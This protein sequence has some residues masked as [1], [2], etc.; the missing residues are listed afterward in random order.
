VGVTVS[1]EN[2]NLPVL[3]TGPFAE[4]TGRRFTDDRVSIA[5]GGGRSLL[6]A[7]AGGWDI[8]DIA[9]NPIA[10]SIGGIY[11][12]DTDYNLTTG[13]FEDY[14]K[15]LGGGGTVSATV[16]LKQPPRNLPRLVATGMAA[17]RRISENPERCIV[18]IRSW[19]S[20]T[21]LLRTEPFSRRDIDRVRG[22]CERMRFDL[23]YYYGMEEDEANRFNI[24][25]DS[26]YHRTILPMI[27]GDRRFT[28][29]YVFSVD[30]ATDDRPYFSYFFRVSRLGHLFAQTGRQWLFVVEG[31][32]I[33]LFATFA[34]TLLLAA[35]FILLP[36]LC[37]RRYWKRG[38]LPVLLY[39]SMIAI[40]FMFI[41]I[42][43][44]QKFRRHIANPLYSNSMIIAALLI[45]TGIAS[46]FS[47]R[48]EQGRRKKRLFHA[49]LG[50]SLYLL[51]LMAALEFLFPVMTPVPRIM[52]L[53]LPILTMIPLGLCMGLFFPLGMSAL[54][55]GDAAALPWAWSVNGFFSV[56]AS[57]GTVLV[58][59]NA[60]LL[61]TALAALLCYWM[62]LLF[63][64]SA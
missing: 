11:S 12:A 18:V 6:H 33:V 57:T 7:S 59:S 10:S 3:L 24:V 45:S 32:Y 41:E 21:M 22:F 60:G 5:M 17:V 49:L 15:A 8:V 19:S 14:L 42:L 29:S 9:E 35:V 1:E 46:F 48:I 39:F 16:P 23:V 43:L 40:G 31:G 55:V 47:D 54:K 64:P 25:E 13:A 58:A 37:A 56:L 27:R 62:A 30:P 2:P 28:R 20:G 52:P 4:F 38:R 36:P 61:A 50:L 53:L 26:I 34:A 51:L 63:F 44:M